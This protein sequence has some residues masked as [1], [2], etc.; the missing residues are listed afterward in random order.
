MPYKTM[1]DN[2][3]D[4]Q[5]LSL[6]NIGEGDVKSLAQALKDTQITRLDLS[7]NNIGCNGLKYL[8]QVLRDTLPHLILKI[9][10]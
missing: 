3:K 8:T 2:L 7:N 5:S 4:N 6:S 10:I 1:I 9:T